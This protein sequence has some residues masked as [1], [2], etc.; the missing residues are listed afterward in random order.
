M[1]HVSK[2]LIPAL[3]ALALPAVTLAA[4]AVTTTPVPIQDD[5]PEE[6]LEWLQE[7]YSNAYSPWLQKY[8]AAEDDEAREKLV[9]SH[10][11]RDFAPLFVAFA[12]EHPGT[13]HAWQ[14]LTW[15]TSQVR[16]G[17]HLTAAVGLLA[18]DHVADPRLA[19]VCSALRQSPEPGVSR[20][21]RTISESSPN[22]DVQ[23]T[24]S[25]SLGVQLKLRASETEGEAAATLLADFE[26]LMQT[27]Q[28]DFAE[29]EMFGST[30]KTWAAGELFEYENLRIG[31]TAPD[32]VGEDIDGVPFQLSDYRGKVGMLDF[33][34]HW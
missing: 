28:A 22:R 18:R 21:L 34:G 23:G 16:E 25:F 19:D 3:G 4:H 20:G 33:W 14:A 9:A 8:T 13:D 7:E 2:W 1:T 15:V 11:A 31:M 12:G 17:E 24:A 5:D 29:V 26:K 27:V 30:L 32:I 10:P 6:E